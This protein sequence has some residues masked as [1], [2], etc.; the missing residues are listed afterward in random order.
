[1]PGLSQ[2]G[3]GSIKRYRISAYPPGG[4]YGIYIPQSPEADNAALVVTR[5]GACKEINPRLLALLPPPRTVH[6][7]PVC[8]YS[9]GPFARLE[10]SLKDIAS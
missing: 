10:S 4:R 6:V 7:R 1:M 8:A 3:P 2:T 9:L 5:K